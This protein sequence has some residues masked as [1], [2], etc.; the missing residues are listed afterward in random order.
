MNLRVIAALVCLSIPGASA[1]AALGTSAAVDSTGRLWIAY[2]DS[3]DP[4]T[5]V[6]VARSDDQGD[7]WRPAVRA[8]SQAEPVSADGENRPKL[9]FGPQGD[10][11]VSWTSPTSAQYTADIRFARS[12]DEG[13]TWSAPVVVHRDRQVITHRFESMAVDRDGRIWV[14]WIDKRDLNIAEAAGSD[15]AGAAVYYAYSEDRGASWQGDFKLTDHSCECCRIALAIDAQ[16]RA[17]AMWRHV[18]ESSERDHA[19]AV[20]TPSGRAPSI[21][22]AT[23][24][25]WRIDACPHH[26]PGLAYDGKNLR[27]AV[28]F[29]QSGGEGRAFYGQLTQD[30]PAQ[31][32]TL[33]PGASHADVAS[34]G[35]VVAIAWKRFDG[36]STRIESWL[37][38]DSGATFTGAAVLDT[39]GDSDQ[40]RLVSTKDNILLVWRRAE[41]VAVQALTG[42]S[43][44]TRTQQYSRAAA[45][46][47][48]RTPV[49]PFERNTL[50]GIERMHAG[51]S[52]W[53]VLW[54][55]ECTYCMKSLQNLAI[56]QRENP[57]LKVVTI[58]TDPISSAAQLEDRLKT[59]G[60]ASDAYAFAGAPPEALRYSIDPAWMGEKPRAY[61]YD[62]SGKREAIN[63][64]I[65]NWQ[66]FVPG[67]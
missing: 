2:A 11:Y 55:L 18:F 66:A 49:K 52:Y 13:R 42:G 10:L 5:H 22:R 26:G 20:L 25:R 30:G 21:E 1:A 38:R 15:Y 47:P 12:L 23:F 43:A 67:D 40:P 9:A 62:A 31:I 58:A 59:L 45:D 7:S 64:V 51:Q 16:G 63:G 14:A 27:H 48:S 39:K 6:M 57:S 35:D 24:D 34:L 3:A 56:A 29:N 46:L 32:H 33:P 8:T 28:W 36:K 65:R 41:G 54:D 19:F 37:S 4:Q 50:A 53:L 44:S 61:R 17:T 60:V